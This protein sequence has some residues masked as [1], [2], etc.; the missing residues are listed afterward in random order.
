MLTEW[1]HGQRGEYAAFIWRAV[2]DPAV[3]AEFRR[4]PRYRAV[5]ETLWQ[6][7]GQAYL[8][9]IEDD[10]VRR[11]CLDSAPADTVGGPLTYDYGG[12]RL[13]P[14]T[15]RYG[16]VLDD[17]IRFFPQF[18]TVE[19]LVEIGI[20]HGGQARLVAAHAATAG[21]RLRRYTCLDLAPVLLLARQ[22]LEHFRLAPQFRFLSKLELDADARWDLA[23]SNYAFSELGLALQ[24][25]YLDR[26]LTRAGSGYLTMNSG[27]TEGA[28]RGQK[29]LTV[30]ALLRRLENAVLCLEEPA[31]S[32]DNYVV[33]YGRHAAPGLPL[34]TV[35]E[36]ARA[37]AAAIPV[38][39]ARRRLL[40]RIGPAERG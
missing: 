38:K 28:W 33:V 36:A 39:P 31:T 20:G 24:E 23:T 19:D 6:E 11:L 40:S 15:L 18:A 32:P 10:G 16:K 1:G 5:V 29:C 12:A 25:E 17:L 8:D 21:T 14:T 22:Y 35:R 37:R 7:T 26:V 13:A 3:F 2:T 27:L 4:D 34:A 9:R 30:E